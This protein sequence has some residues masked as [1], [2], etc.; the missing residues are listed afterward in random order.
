MSPMRM[1]MHQVSIDADT[2]L[3]EAI[4]SQ[5]DADEDIQTIALSAEQC[6][7]VAAW[8]EQVYRESQGDEVS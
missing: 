3:G 5:G 2:N 1:S 4:I 7:T 8:L 6:R